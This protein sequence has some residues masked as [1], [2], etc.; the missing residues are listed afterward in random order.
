SYVGQGDV[1]TQAG[2]DYRKVT[3]NS[4][5]EVLTLLRFGRF[6]E[7]L[8]NDD[9]PADD[10]AAAIWDFAFGYASLKMGDIGTAIDIQSRISDFAANTDGMFRFHPASR[11]V[12]TLAQMLAGEIAW[13]QGNLDAAISA[14]ENAVSI[15]DQLDYDEPEPLPFSARHWLGAALLEARRYDD[16]AQVYEAELADHPRNGWSLYGLRAALTGQG[17]SDPDINLDFVESWARADVWITSSKF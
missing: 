4:L 12:G 10:V 1:A 9:R 3:G 15:E 2:K 6:D 8:A 17:L 14:F 11:V 5:Y 16:A 7:V 13:F